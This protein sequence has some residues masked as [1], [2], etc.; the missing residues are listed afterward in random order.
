ME[1]RCRKDEPTGNGGGFDAGS[2]HC[3]A[4]CLYFTSQVDVPGGP[5]SQLGLICEELVIGIGG[6]LLE[7]WGTSV[8]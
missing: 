8:R 6:W 1:G 5:V 2:E 4:F 3:A 7:V